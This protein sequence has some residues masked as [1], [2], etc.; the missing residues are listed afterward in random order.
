MEVN[1]RES[2]AVD[3]IALMERVKDGRDEGRYPKSL[4]VGLFE[5]TSHLDFSSVPPENSS[6]SKVTALIAHLVKPG[7]MAE[8]EASHGRL[9][10]QVDATKGLDQ[11]VLRTAACV[12]E[13]AD[14]FVGL[15]DAIVK[16]G[17]ADYWRRQVR[18]IAQERAKYLA[19]A[20]QGSDVDGMLRCVAKMKGRP[21]PQKIYVYLSYCSC[22]VSY[23]L[24]DSEFV[25]CVEDADDSR[26][27]IRSIV[28]E[29]FH[30][31]AGDD[32][33]Q[34]YNDAIARDGYLRDLMEDNEW[35]CGI[36]VE[37]M[38]VKAVDLFV[39][40][41]ASLYTREEGFV[42]LD[43]LYG[44]SLPLS[45]VV[46]DLLLRK[47]ECI[48]DLNSW[49]VGRFDDGT[50]RVGGI[51][52][53]CDAILPGYSGRLDKSMGGHDAYLAKLKEHGLTGFS[54]C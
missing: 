38:F 47:G 20:I 5:A 42:I 27:M 12:I 22:P 52:S 40:V 6:S 16:A 41:R 32:L 11:D 2:L 53:Q 9:E 17:F 45:V 18:E 34:R 10:K 29:L 14:V 50:I 30:G 19:S 44:N 48:D 13:H 24:T 15:I 33:A 7:V 28:H 46:L 21:G 51:A 54:D 31:F 36:G 25:Q 23:H 8:M 26:Y 4:W 1:F 49:L 39:S 3:T 35:R 37:E 43:G